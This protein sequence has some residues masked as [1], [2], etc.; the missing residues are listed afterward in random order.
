MNKDLKPYFEDSE[1]VKELSPSD[2][3]SVATWKLK[4][5][6]CTAILFYAPWCP[7]C[8]AVK[9]EWIN[10]GKIATFMDVAALNCEKYAGY[11]LKIKEDMPYLIGGFPTIV[12]YVNGEPF[13]NYQGERTMKKFVKKGM[14][15]CQSK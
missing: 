3:N 7:H 9:D 15:V 1:Y 2:F 8:K 5:T 11:V 10:F 6:A 12:F 4:N 14:E 13:D